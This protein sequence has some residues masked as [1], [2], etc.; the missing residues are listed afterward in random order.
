MK[1]IS[2]FILVLMTLSTQA[3]EKPNFIIFFADDLGYNDLS[4]F[5]SKKI[6][7]PNI[8]KLGIDGAK[9]TNFYAQSICGP[10]RA[11]LLTGS[12]PSRIAQ[13]GKVRQE[14]HPWM[15]SSE[16]TIAE[17][18][19]KQGYKTG[20][21]GK[22]GLAHHAPSKFIKELLPT[23]Q[24]FDYFYGVQASNDIFVDIIENEKIIKKKAKMALLT[25]MY[26]DKV[27][28]FIDKNQKSPFFAY[29][30]YT[31]P[32]VKI[33]ASKKFKGKSPYGLY[34]D[35]VEEIDFNVGRVM[36]KIEQLNLSDNTYIIFT[37]DN[38]PWFL[39]KLVRPGVK[40]DHGGSALP[41][42]GF[43]TSTWEGGLR[44]P[45]VVK[46]P[47]IPANTVCDEIASTLD[48]MPTLAKLAGTSAPADRKIDGEDISSLLFAKKAKFD[49]ARTFYF[50]QLYS[51]QAVRVGDWKLHVPG[52]RVFDIHL[53]KHEFFKSKKAVL[54]NLKNDVSES[55]DVAKSHPEI[56]KQL[57]KKIQDMNV[58]LGD[59]KSIGPESRNR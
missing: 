10:S 26:T 2:I 56:V 1:Y 37:S 19:K 29:V 27:L 32:H 16:I 11:S 6:R 25:Q 38:G 53:P 58:K 42:R 34:A 21:F 14:H 54:Y 7:T 30:P 51:L 23:R 49:E 55:R 57:M 35:V 46:G 22:W 13:K 3:N 36:K 24:G 43:K 8:D 31:M 28:Q 41:L 12:Y 15:A 45:F 40:A 4:S 39:D 47:K 33:D 44:V 59:S 50:Y 52:K 20:C 18:L 17:V 48:L 5:G 9:F